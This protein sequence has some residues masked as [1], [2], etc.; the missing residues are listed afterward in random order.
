MKIGLA[1]SGGGVRATVFHLGVLKRLAQIPP[2]REINFLSTVSGGSLCIALVFEKAGQRWPSAQQFLGDCLPGIRKLLTSYDLEGQYKHLLFRRPWLS[3]VG[4]ASLVAELIREHWGITSTVAQMP[5]PPRWEICATCYQTGKGWR[6]SKRRMGDYLTNYV[7]A[8]DFPLAEA[9]ATSAAVPG[10]IGPLRLKT[11]K[12]RWHKFAK[13]GSEP[14]IEVEPI[15]PYL[16]LWDGGIYENL[17]VEAIF[18]PQQG[19]REEVDFLITSDASK[20]LGIETRRFQWGLPPYLP[21]FRLIDV[22]MDQVRAIRLRTIIGFLEQNKGAGVILR[23]GNTVQD[24]LQKAKKQP[25]PSWR[26]RDFLSDAEVRKATGLETTLRKLTEMEFDR[27]LDHGYEVA[28]ST[29]FAYDHSAF[30]E[31]A[32][33]T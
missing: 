28:E 29:L 27:L 16:A 3:F 15:A 25:P 21:P 5:D 14:T 26:N 12:Y 33:V 18:K 19:L 8:P 4:R 2:W 31:L 22:A 20:P 10:V 24:I 32:P 7:I 6:F 9:A 23:M 13:D 11:S 1:L 17:G 30:G